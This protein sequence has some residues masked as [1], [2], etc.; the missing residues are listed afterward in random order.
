MLAELSSPL[1]WTLLGMGIVWIVTYAVGMWLGA[2]N[3]D[4]S[5]RLALPAKLV[6]IALTLAM[7]IIWLIAVAGSP[8]TT[9][10]VLIVLGLIAGAV[11]DLLLADVL[12]VKKPEMPA[13]AVFGVGHLL[14]LAAAIVFSTQMQLNG[15]R[16]VVAAIGGALVIALL[17]AALVATG[18]VSR[19]M[20]LGSLIY[21]MLIGI[22]AGVATSVRLTSGALLSLAVGLILFALSDLLLAR[23]L[24]RKQGFTSVR[25]VVWLIYS[26]AQILIAASI[27]GAA[28]ALAG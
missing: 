6:M 20:N 23:Y 16:M 4:R 14:Y 15:G 2:P 9:Y 17:W 12:P 7:G 1:R 27:G 24:L 13:M 8:A 22:V 19:T 21:G 18:R 10:G 3:D 5:R 28:I 11:G 26:L 25:D